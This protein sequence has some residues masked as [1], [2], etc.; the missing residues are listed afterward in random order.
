MSRQRSSLLLF[1][2]KIIL[3]R[4]VSKNEK[5]EGN[6]TC[7]TN[8]TDTSIIVPRDVVTCKLVFSYFFVAL[9]YLDVY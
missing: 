7:I 5:N 6:Q 3:A 1:I 9:L 2:F 4:L 8:I